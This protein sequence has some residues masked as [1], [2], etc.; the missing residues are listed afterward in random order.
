M[1]QR[2]HDPVETLFNAEG[3][4]ALNLD[5]RA[6]DAARATLAFLGHDPAGFEI[7][8][9]ACN[10]ARIAELNA[11]FRGKPKPTNVLSWP[12]EDRAAAMPGGNP[13]PP[14]AFIPGDIIELGDVAIAL[15]TCKREAAEAGRA[16]EDHVCH[17]L[18]HGFLHLLGY[19]HETDEDA[20][21]MEGLETRI[22]AKLGVADPYADQGGFP[23]QNG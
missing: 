5:T 17:L 11:D 1:T 13:S 16:I 6:N 21:L 12:S 20:A 23:D 7:S 22:L 8:L 3:W 2:M 10:D 4:K 9:L 14:E 15:E 19:D 18:V